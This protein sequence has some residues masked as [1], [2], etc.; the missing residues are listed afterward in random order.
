MTSTSKSLETAQGTEKK[1][2]F[3]TQMNY[4]EKYGLGDLKG[5]SLNTGGLKDRFDY[6][7]RD[8]IST[9]DIQLYEVLGERRSPWLRQ[10]ITPKLLD[11]YLHL[12]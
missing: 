2:G 11:H 6:A 5:W 4:S 8:P 3:L 12:D 9:F 1:C 10:I 7:P